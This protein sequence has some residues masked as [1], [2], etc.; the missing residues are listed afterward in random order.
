MAAK[1]RGFG[2][3]R[4]LPSKRYQAGYTGP[5]TDMH[6]AASTFET[7]ED[8]EAWLADE[9]RLIAAG[10]WTA[11]KARAKAKVE[12]P[13]TFGAYAESWLRRRD[14]KP[15]T[16]AHYRRLLDEFIMPRFADVPFA[17]ITPVAVADWHADLGTATGPTYRA[18]AYSL[19]R[20]I[21]LTAVS[22]DVIN[23]SPCRVRGAG[24][25][26]RVKKIEPAT[27]AELEALT[28]AMPERL[29]AMVMLA[30]WCAMRFG[31]L[32]ELRRKDV[33][34]KNGVIHVRRAVVRADGEVIVG[35]PKSDAGI[36]DIAVPP[37][38]VPMLKAHI[39]EHGQWG[40]DG[41]LFPNPD[42]G[43]M[44]SSSLA[45]HFNKARIAAKRPDL[46][47]HD[48]RHT[49]AVLA[50]QTGATLAELMARL[51]HSTPSAALRYQHAAKG[52]DA[53]IAALLSKI[54]EAE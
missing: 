13:M 20:T 27:L 32:A 3:I 9:R 45:W 2:Q 12:G 23:A 7:R 6:Y 28:K 31:E 34:L 18:H 51:G 14:L 48:L 1:K 5:D 37:H 42:G 25:S 50:A 53:E 41:L 35:T 38:L 10:T 30:A 22:E 26:K 36:R 47:F 21:S 15:R 54:A 43:N 52:R 49:G 29:R 11:P 8:A 33:D 19:L 4:R 40:K 16:R 17:H 44:A 46:R 39:A 24:N